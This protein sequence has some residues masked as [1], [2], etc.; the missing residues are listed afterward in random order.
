MLDCVSTFL[1]G[2]IASVY[3]VDQH[4]KADV[5]VN[6]MSRLEE[7]DHIGDVLLKGLVL[8]IYYIDQCYTAL[9]ILLFLL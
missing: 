4:F 6:S 9:E 1:G 7:L 8:C 2:E 3:F 5:W